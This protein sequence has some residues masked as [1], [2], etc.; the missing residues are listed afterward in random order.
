[1]K[2]SF[3]KI[4]LSL[5]ATLSVICVNT[6]SSEVIDFNQGVP[7]DFSLEGGMSTFD[8]YIND[9]QYDKS[10]TLVFLDP[11]F[12]SSFDLNALPWEDYEFDIVTSTYPIVDLDIA[13]NTVFEI[14][15]DLSNYATYLI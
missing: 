3:K 4:V 11:V 9:N 7:Y 15:V 8:G 1:M 6:N 2:S 14:E 13:G 10:S 5:L 12:V